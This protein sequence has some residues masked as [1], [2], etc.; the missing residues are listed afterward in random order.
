MPN[1]IIIA[2]GLA[3]GYPRN[4]IWRNANLSIGPGEFVG[5]LGPNGAGKTTLFRLLLGLSK[6]LSGE[7]HIFGQP[8]R[9]GSPRIGYIP[10]RRPIDEQ[11]NL[12]ALELVRLGINSG[13]WG[14]AVP[15]KARAERAQ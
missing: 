7:L 14:F 5:I 10:Q 12:E 11:L 9:R 2:E 13:G 8:P 1:D 6:P 3:A 4:E 15:E